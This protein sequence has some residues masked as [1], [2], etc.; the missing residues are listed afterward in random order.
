MMRTAV[1]VLGALSFV[2]VFF[3]PSMARGAGN[4][5]RFSHKTHAPL[6]MACTKCHSMDGKG[7]VAGYP[8]EAEC[9]VCHTKFT[10][11]E[12][13]FPTTRVY[14][15]PDFVFFSHRVHAD[16]KAPC[17]RCHG[18][19]SASDTVKLEVPPFM[20]MCVDCHR[21]TKASI[22]CFVCHEIGQ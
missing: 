15:L 3:M 22:D 2:P 16:A 21:E 4:V 7:G 8:G 19:V 18:D 13:T 5:S 10:A 20:K 17:A 1:V 6:R 9:K 11:A 14:R 12:T